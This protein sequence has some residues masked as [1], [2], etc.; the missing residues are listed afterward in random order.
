MQ[1]R[2]LIIG[3]IFLL[4]SGNLM[5]THNRA[6]EITYEQMGDYIYKVTVTTITNTKPTSDGITPADRPSL[7]IIWGDNS[8]SDL[9]RT[10]LTDLPN[11]YRK[12]TYVGL[13]KFP[14]P[15]IYSLVVEDPNRNEGV[16]NIPNSVN[17]VFSIKTQLVIDPILGQNS[18]PILTN[19]PID[20]A[21]VGKIFIHNP[22]AYDPDGDSLSYEM[23]VCTGQNGEPIANYS[24]PESS[25][26]PVYIDPVLGNLI[27][28]APTKTGIY[29]VA[30]LIKEWRKGVKVGQ[31]TRDMQ[32]EVFESEN[33]PP[34]IDSILPM[35]LIAND[36]A[37]FNVTA[38]DNAN[39]TITLTVAGGIF[40]FTPPPVFTSTP[41][42]G[43]VTGH[44]KWVP[45][46][47]YVRKQPYQIVFKAEDNNR[48]VVLT[49][50]MTAEITVVGPEVENVRLEPNSNSI[51]LTW[52]KY[53]SGIHK[54]IQIYRNS[55][56]V[57]FIPDTCET[58]VPASTGYKLIA[59]LTDTTAFTYLDN[60]NGKGLTQ[61]YEYCY[62][63]TALYPDVESRASVEVCAQLE[64]GIPIITHVSVEKSDESKGEIYLEWSKPIEFDSVKYQGPYQYI[65]KRALGIWGTD[66]Q[67]I[68][69]L[70][71]LNDTI[72]TDKNLNTFYPGY[73]YK[74][75]IH[76]PDGLTEQPMT[77]SSL[78]PKPDGSN[79]A[80][81]LTITGNI[82]WTNYQYTIYRQ[83]NGQPTFD[84]VGY[85]TTEFFTDTNL[86]NLQTYCYQVKSFGAYNLSGIVKP[87]VNLS[88]QVCSQPIDTI[89]PKPPVIAVD[90]SCSNF[91]TSLSWTKSQSDEPVYEY[92]I[93]FGTN[94]SNMTAID[95]VPGDGALTYNI[96]SVE[97]PSGCYGITAVDS[98]NNESAISNLVC[99][100]VCPYYELPNVFTPN[101]D[102]TND[103]FI[104]ITPYPVI[105]RYV[106][107]IDLQV[108]SRWGNLV[109][110]TKDKF[111]NWDGKSKQTHQL[112][113]PGV[114]YYVCNVW[115]RRLSGIQERY[116]V[117]FV[118]V[119]HNQK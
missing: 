48:E 72:Y 56:P 96:I 45:S 66:Y 71:S 26:K 105:D 94:E 39:E 33:S 84:S 4:F 16:E 81:R 35:C 43:I 40:S 107:K 14:G 50:Q 86:V 102:K 36:S 25:H 54:A 106:E 30:F 95:T 51:S 80:I 82:P 119:F 22:G 21:A 108:F 85:S 78:Y 77:A 19:L 113:S 37:S 99:S 116:L 90:V 31:I 60:N 5:A 23:T 114:Y 65:I 75:E 10:T 76:N 62:I 1:Y 6:G 112:V 92:R 13:H 29:N 2:W 79:K 53:S 89:A 17:V 93:Y 55:I 7:T 27:W 104:P 47:K 91:N 11:F 115:E 34:V 15:G 8:Y 18:T 70:N 57:N 32:I 87:I 98:T 12:N 64:R 109:F 59:T 3:T 42:Q 58:G 9:E 100:D 61:G 44:F 97:N 83:T 68:A 69:T 117:G 24:L 110:E 38:R 67:T 118:H 28:D 52:D 41:A 111:I 20:K 46:P 88:H 73:S 101:N 49:H 103:L 74:V 63:L